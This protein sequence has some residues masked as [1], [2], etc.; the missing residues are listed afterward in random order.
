MANWV[1]LNFI[2]IL[3][4]RFRKREPVTQWLECTPDKCKAGSSNLPR[5]KK[6]L[7]FDYK[8]YWLKSVLSSVWIEHRPSK[9]W[10]IG[11]NPIGRR[12][13]KVIKALYK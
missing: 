13:I 9:P 2:S 7:F 5:L 1:W 4:H 11:S 3:R 8:R 12:N 6:S 10:D